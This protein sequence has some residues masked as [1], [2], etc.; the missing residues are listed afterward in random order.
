VNFMIKVAVVGDSNYGYVFPGPALSI[1]KALFFLSVCTAPEM[2]PNSGLG[3]ISGSG[4]FRGAVQCP[5]S[6]LVL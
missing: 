2:I 1:L 5:V 4:S 6:P 3:I